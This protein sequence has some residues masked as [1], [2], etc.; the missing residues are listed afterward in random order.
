MQNINLKIARI[1]KE[2][3]QKDLAKI[4]GSTEATIS[5]LEQGLITNPRLSLMRKISKALD[6]PIQELFFKEEE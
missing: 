5:R 2:Y 3:R 4:V 6:T 1:K